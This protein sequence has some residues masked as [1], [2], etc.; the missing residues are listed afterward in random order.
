VPVINEVGQVGDPVIPGPCDWPLDVSCV[1]EWDDATNEQRSRAIS[2]A[3]FILDALTGHQFAQCPITVRPC[4]TKCGMRVAY[5]TYPV[6]APANGGAGPWM[7]PYILNGLWRNCGCAGGCSC[8]P[9]CRVDLMGPVAEVTEV[10][11]DGLVLDPAAYE[12]VGQWLVRTDGG[13]C[14][15]SCQDPSV[16]DTEEGTFSVTFR[17]GRILPVAGQ[18]AAGI[19]A[20]EFLKS[21]AGSACQLPAQISSLTRQGVDVEFVDPITVF[22]DGRTG[23]ADV[24]RFINAVN[25]YT[26]R[27]RS[28][29]YSPDVRSHAVRY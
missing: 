24:D 7:T 6:M 4:G 28:R 12:L 1:P 20:G 19:L 26:N 16:P 21:C 13:E 11:V 18:I 8:L 2:W 23:I 5:Q 9:S 25:P 27:Q 14:W 17:P 22:E 10:R 29:V 15:P 3:T